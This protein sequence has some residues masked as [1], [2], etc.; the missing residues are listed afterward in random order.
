MFCGEWCVRKYIGEVRAHENLELLYDAIA[1][2]T[3]A[4][5]ESMEK[6][7]QLHTQVGFARAE[8]TRELHA[9]DDD[10]VVFYVEI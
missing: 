1:R 2:N 6:L 8:R 3:I 10:L 9:A 7:E 4:I 5:T